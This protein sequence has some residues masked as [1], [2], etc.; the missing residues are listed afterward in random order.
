M[1]HRSRLL[2]GT[3]VIAGLSLIGSQA[4]PEAILSSHCFQ[5]MCAN[6]W[7]DGRVTY[8]PNTANGVAGAPNNAVT[9]NGIV[10]LSTSP[11]VWSDSNGNSETVQ[12]WS[13]N[14]GTPGLICAG[15]GCATMLVN[16]P[17]SL[18]PQPKKENL[19]LEFIGLITLSGMAVG[20]CLGVARSIVWVVE[21]HRYLKAVEGRIAELEGAN[22]PTKEQI[23]KVKA[24]V[25]L[26]D[27][28]AIRVINALR[29]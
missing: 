17:Y 29:D 24:V 13:G 8:T 1:T 4:R 6:L 22:E 18:S 16:S 20:V 28:E 23:A 21:T 27:D 11:L 3:A 19:M 12:Q 25:D 5:T 2:V 26:T 7:Q 9:N 10:T 14:V 15:T